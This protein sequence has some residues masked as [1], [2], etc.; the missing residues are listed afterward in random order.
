MILPLLQLT[1]VFLLRGGSALDEPLFVSPR[2]ATRAMKSCS[3]SISSFS[4]HHGSLERGARAAPLRQSCR[5]KSY[6][7]G[8][9]KQDLST[10]VPPRQGPSDVVAASPLLASCRSHTIPSHAPPYNAR[11]RSFRKTSGVARQALGRP[12]SVQRA[13]ATVPERD[14]QRRVRGTPCRVP[15]RVPRA[16]VSSRVRFQR[17]RGDQGG[18]A[19]HTPS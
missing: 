9:T 2:P 3:C 7:Q 1:K 18:G 6:A 12:S 17:V 5:S 19:C 10:A 14:S 11:P 4:R 15:S 8:R 13:G 16:V